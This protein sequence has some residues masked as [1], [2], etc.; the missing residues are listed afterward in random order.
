MSKPSVRGACLTGALLLAFSLASSAQAPTA[1]TDPSGLPAEMMP[2]AAQSLLLDAVQSPAGFFVAGERG[3]ILTSRDGRGWKQLPV[4]TRSSLNAL[5][6]ADGQ[7]WAG[8]HDG[9]ILHSGDGGATWHVQRRD[10]FMLAE[11][12][13]PADRDLRQGAPV[14]DLLFADA[15]SGI[16][17]GAYSL[18]LQ[19]QDGGATWTQVD[20]LPDAPGAVDEP[21]IV[22]SESGVFAAE[23]LELG[24]EDNPH[25]NAIAR[26][27]SGALVVVGERGTVLR[28]RD[29]GATWQKVR[30][31]YAGSLFGVLGWDA[32]HV[33]AFGLRGNVYESFDLG[34]TW[35]K[36]DSG[37]TT[38]VMGGVALE[39]GG[40]VLVGSNGAVLTRVEAGEGFRGATYRNS[41]QETPALA[42]VLPAGSAGLVVV[43]EKG[44]DTY[45][46]EVTENP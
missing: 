24:E 7:L 46:A 44:V 31:P 3:H 12:E 9:V 45:S 33:L 19:T 5:A 35:T 34:D 37:V 40:A 29:N 42:G 36:V 20:A 8:G 22:A 27:G 10:P 1:P 32:D 14:L 21:E 43:G 25:F 15:S 41:A 28:S 13:D 38:N 2:R 26:T 30:F 39:G 17:V 11:G 18:M 23:D 16:A 4:P 6:T